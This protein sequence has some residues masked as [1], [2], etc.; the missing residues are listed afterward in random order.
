MT[1]YPTWKYRYFRLRKVDV[2]VLP[3]DKT[4]WYGVAWYGDG[5]AVTA[6]RGKRKQIGIMTGRKEYI[7]DL[8][9]MHEDQ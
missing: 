5:D 7:F 2:N 4:R 8:W 6:F 3:E 9:K 1:K